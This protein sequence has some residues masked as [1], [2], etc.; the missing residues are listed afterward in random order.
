MPARNTGIGLCRP[1]TTLMRNKAPAFQRVNCS[2]SLW[3]TSHVQCQDRWNVSNDDHFRPERHRAGR[4]S[5]HPYGR[6][7]NTPALPSAQSIARPTRLMSISIE[8]PD[9][10]MRMTRLPAA[11]KSIHPREINGRLWSDADADTFG[12]AMSPIKADDV[13][14][15]L[16][17]ISLLLE[18]I[19]NFAA[20]K[21]GCVPASLDAE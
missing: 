19:A 5:C 16:T 17:R 15:F 12:G 10:L 1:R 6:A 8:Y 4:C 9:P 21:A 3:R 14:Q 18:A 2:T 13:R 20:S 11:M 7:A